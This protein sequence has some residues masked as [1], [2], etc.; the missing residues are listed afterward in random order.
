ME[1]MQMCASRERF[2]RGAEADH[3]RIGIAGWFLVRSAAPRTQKF[4]VTGKIMTRLLSLDELTANKLALRVRGEF[5]EMPG[6]RLNLAQAQR[7]WGLDSTRCEAIL[8][9]LV[10][11]G[12]LTCT[13]E[14]MFVRR[15]SQP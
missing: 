8:K 7:L 1:F 5:M 9:A 6:L 12:F 11:M 14:Q 15:A 2:V 10:D 13:R 3:K 4:A